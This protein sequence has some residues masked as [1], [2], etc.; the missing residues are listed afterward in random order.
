MA[1]LQSLVPKV[2]LGS[3]QEECQVSGEY[4]YEHPLYP[5]PKVD[6]QVIICFPLWLCIKVFT[7]VLFGGDQLTAERARG[8]QRCRRNELL[9]EDQLRGLVPVAAEWHAKQCLLQVC[10]I[11]KQCI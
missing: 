11:Y 2:E 5:V 4:K 6:A 3:D 8:A 1:T 10:F 7:K 9:P